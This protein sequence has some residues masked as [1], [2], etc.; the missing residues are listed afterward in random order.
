MRVGDDRRR[1]GRGMIDEDA[2]LARVPDLVLAEILQPLHDRIDEGVVDHDAR[3]RHDDEIAR[4]HVAVRLPA[5]DDLGDGLA[6]AHATTHSRRIESSW[7]IESGPASARLLMRNVIVRS[8]S[9][10]NVSPSSSARLPTALWPV[11]L[12]AMLMV[13]LSPKSA[14]SR[15]S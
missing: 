3:D 11:S 10:P 15:I 2:D 1:S 12:W 8:S 5:E 13:R 4:A 9:F 6:A 14:G 7:S